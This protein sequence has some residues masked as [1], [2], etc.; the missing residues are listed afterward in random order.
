MQLIV[1][2]SNV[3]I[4]MEAGG[5]LEDMFRLESLDFAVPDLLYVE[6]L[7]TRR[8]LLPGLGLR[9]LPMSEAVVSDAE[10]LSAC[11]KRASQHDIFALALARSERCPLLS[12]DADLR[13]AA[14]AEG[15]EVHGTIWLVGRM[16]DELR[17][18][19]ARVENAYEQM[20]NDGSRLPWAEVQNQV[21]LWRNQLQGN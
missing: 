3:F 16:F 5:L 17:L 11:Y 18:D 13:S 19:I 1:T 2:D 9:V 6:E 10:A 20:R 21:R 4:D 15:V 8:P 7:A 12:G 14:E